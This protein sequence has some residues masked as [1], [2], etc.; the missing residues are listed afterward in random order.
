MLHDLNLASVFADRILLLDK[1]EVQALG[2]PAEVLDLQRIS[3]I[4]KAEVTAYYHPE[5]NRHLV[6]L[7]D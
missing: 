1:G 6:M 2:E 4:Y 3:S 7:D 5:N